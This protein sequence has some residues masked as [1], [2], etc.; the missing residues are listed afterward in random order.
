MGP[1]DLV[2][3]CAE[4]SLSPLP[5]MDRPLVQPPVGDCVSRLPD[6]NPHPKSLDRY[7]QRRSRSERLPQSPRGAREVQL[8]E[9]VTGAE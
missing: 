2:R 5:L 8:N 6:V 1:K 9:N 7:K 4:P 3:F